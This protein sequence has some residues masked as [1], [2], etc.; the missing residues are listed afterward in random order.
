M[1]INRRHWLKKL[2]VG[3]SGIG[4]TNFNTL[5][6]ITT[7][8]FEPPL[9]NGS[10]INL[11]SNE[12]P[13]GPSP[14][15]KAAMA[16]SIAISNRYNW[17][18]SMELV[19]ALAQKHNVGADHILL[20]AGSTEIIDLVVRFAATNKGNLVI[21][22]PSYSNWIGTAKKQ[23][24]RVIKV[25][26]NAQKAIDLPAMQKAILPD[27]RL[28]YLCNP[29]NPTGTICDRTQLLNF[30]NEATQKAVVLVD[31][32]YLDFCPQ[33]SLSALTLENK[34]LIVVKTFSKLYGLAGARIGY[35][36]G[37]RST[38]DQLSALQSWPNGAVSVVS[39]SAALASLQ[40][41]KFIKETYDLNQKV[42]QYTVAQLERLNILCIPSH[43]NFIY[44]SLANYKRDYF[45]QLNDQHI[46]ATSIYEEAGLWT[47]IT[48][49]TRAEMEKFVGV[50]G[51][52]IR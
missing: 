51:A 2:G 12:N 26:L 30:V 19:E 22:D 35:A 41:E 45:R 40:D 17:Q 27:T 39:V 38:L 23:G 18:L 50:L 48:I 20:G 24:L 6:T 31:E 33:E 7:D 37:H 44:F 11:S 10:P 25:P 52:E 43:T 4:L 36:I 47:R 9:E 42:K 16:K 34:N 29:N 15:A 3:L 1:Y 13:Y 49:G 28:V 5:A 8:F 21:A 14:L 32:A 46:I